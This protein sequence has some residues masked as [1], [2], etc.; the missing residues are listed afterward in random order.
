[1]KL[2]LALVATLITFQAYAQ[3][4]GKEPKSDLEAPSEVRFIPQLSTAFPLYVGV[5][6]SLNLHDH[7]QFK[8]LIGVTPKPYSNTIA[9]VAGSFTNNNSYKDLIRAAFQNNSILRFAFEYRFTNERTGWHVGL[10]ASLLN[11]SGTAGIDQVLS[12]S[13]GRDYTQ[14]RNLIIN[15]GRSADVTMDTRAMIA[16]VEAGYTFEMHEHWSTTLTFGVAKVFSSEVKIKTGLPNYEASNVG[17][18]LLRSTE[19]DIQS[20]LNEYG[21]TPTFGVT[22]SY[23]F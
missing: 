11:A 6:G 2:T 1:M 9:D 19:S 13:T 3:E 12:A 15:S 5:G 17:S 7:F 22:L 10:G 8:A 4:P 23:L 20:I 16:E 18:T 14:L 21:I